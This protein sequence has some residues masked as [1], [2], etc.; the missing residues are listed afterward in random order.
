MTVKGGSTFVI[1]TSN[2]LEMTG[3][4]NIRKWSYALVKVCGIE[5]C[6]LIRELKL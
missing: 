4:E 2:I 6:Y 5:L 1:H 3:Y